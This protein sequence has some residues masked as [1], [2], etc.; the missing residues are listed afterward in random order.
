MIRDP[1]L[2]ALDDLAEKIQ[3]DLAQLRLKLLEIEFRDIELEARKP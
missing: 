1:D 2:K 3:L